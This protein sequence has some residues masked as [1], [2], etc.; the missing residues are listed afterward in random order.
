MCRCVPLWVHVGVCRP[1]QAPLEV[2]VSDALELEFQMVVNPDMR[3]GNR[4]QVLW[5][6]SQC[7]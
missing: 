7:S 1:V 5:K 6:S 3:A 2:G 4:T